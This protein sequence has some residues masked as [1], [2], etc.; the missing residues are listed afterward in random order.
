[1]SRAHVQAA[2]STRRTRASP[3]SLG[4]RGFRKKGRHLRVVVD[5]SDSL[6]NNHKSK[7]KPESSLQQEGDGESTG[8]DGEATGGDGEATGGDGEA[9]GGDGEATG[10]DGEA[11][12]GARS[13]LESREESFEEECDDHHSESSGCKKSDKYVMR[14]HT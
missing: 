5:T 1:M 10:G 13:A 8:G 9:T 7:R 12:G 2:K 14:I 11:T 6:L 4:L 3:S